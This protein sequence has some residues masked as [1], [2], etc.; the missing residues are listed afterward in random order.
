MTNYNERLDELLTE[1]RSGTINFDDRAKQAITSL[2]KELDDETK[3]DPRV[4][5]SVQ[6]TRLQIRTRQDMIKDQ[7]K[8]SEQEA[9]EKAEHDALLAPDK[10]KIIKFCD[11]IDKLR[12]IEVPAVKSKEARVI[13]GEMENFLMT[14]ATK[15]RAKAEKL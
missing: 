6:D 10:E 13:V 3:A 8:K 7:I 4:V 15:A 5:A 9:A 14:L 11:S 2:N 1:L 12:D